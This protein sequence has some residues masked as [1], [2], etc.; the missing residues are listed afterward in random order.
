MNPAHSFLTYREGSL[1][2]IEQLQQL[3]VVSYGQ[4]ASVLTPEHWETMK[5]GFL[6]NEKFEALIRQSTVFVCCDGNRIV[7]MAYFIPHGNPFMV[8][9]ADWSY[10]RIVG[11]DPGYSGKGIA[12]T[13]TA[14]CIA[15][16]KQTGESIIALH[17]SEFMDAARHIYESLGFV[18]LREIDPIFGKRY[19]LYILRLK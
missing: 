2:D 6:N 15:M 10:I 18:K 17:T 9:E 13:L 5:N 14:M 16:G 3:A 4:Y 12:R 1:E 19:W 7:G 11:I 8:F